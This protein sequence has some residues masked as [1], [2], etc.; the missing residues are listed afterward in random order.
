[1]ESAIMN[2]SMMLKPYYE[3][4]LGKLYHG[5][6]LEIMPQLEPV[7]MVLTDPPYGTTVCKW[8][9]II[10][11]YPMWEKIFQLIKPNKP[12]FLFG[13]EPFASYLRISNIEQYRYDWIWYKS[14]SGNVFQYKNS[15]MKRHEPIMVFHE[16]GIAANCYTEYNPK[17]KKC[18][19][20]V[21]SQMT[22]KNN[23]QGMKSPIRHPKPYIMLKTGYPESVLRFAFSGKR[24]HPTQK[25][26]QLIMYFIETYT[27]ENEII[28]DF[29][30]GSG[31][32][33]IACERLKRKW[34]GIEIEEKYCEIAAKR[35][36]QERKQL[37]LF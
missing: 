5:D 10:P 15:P 25:P 28:L 27:K 7:D 13:D 3:T 6:C 1:M 4:P 29:A 35:I 21:F 14:K 24:F 20:K 18:N 19:K 2:G 26:V 16:G 17:M 12:I 30:I 34:I 22:N 23:M 36:E 8:D 11:I 9:A 31:T 32:T 33:A 37:K